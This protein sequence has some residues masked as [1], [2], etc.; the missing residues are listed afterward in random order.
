MPL[1]ERCRLLLPSTNRRRRPLHGTPILV[2]DNIVTFEQVESTAGSLALVGAKPA[3]ES[4]AIAS[5]RSAGCVILGSANCSEWANFRS[6][7]S[8][9]GWS[10]RGGQ[11]RGAYC[12]NM[13][14]GGSSSGSGVAVD[15]GFCVAALGTEV[16][17]SRDRGMLSKARFANAGNRLRAAS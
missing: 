11:T 5:L 6:F 15:M 2:K 16:Q 8:D 12:E 17:G 9:S 10:P 14:P 7:P 1:L 13:D 3:R 4:P